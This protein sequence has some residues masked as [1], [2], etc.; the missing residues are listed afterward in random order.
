MN[1]TTSGSGTCMWLVEDQSGARRCGE[2]AEFSWQEGKA[3]GYPPMPLCREHAQEL[4]RPEEV[5]P[6]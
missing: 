2:T 5:E 3:A 1:E 4:D 6:L